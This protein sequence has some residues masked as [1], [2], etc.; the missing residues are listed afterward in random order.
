MRRR[1]FLHLISRLPAASLACAL[2]P[3]FAVAQPSA[4]RRLIDVHAHV[5]NATDLP[6]RRFLKIVFLHLHPQQGVE[7]L[8]ALKDRDVVD[9]LIEL[10]IRI[11]SGR[12]P[13]ARTEIALLDGTGLAPSGALDVDAAG[14]VT[15][16]RLAEFLREPAPTSSLSR[17][18]RSPTGAAK[19][20]RAVQR[21]GS[22][23]ARDLSAA[24][25]ADAQAVAR[26]AYHSAF[27]I[28]TYLRWFT[29]FS[30]YR[31]TLVDHLA[32]I[33][34]QQGYEPILLAPALID[35]SNWLGEEVASPLADQVEVM[36]RIASRAT[37]PAVHG[38]VGFDPLGEVFHRRMGVQTPSSLEV[39][40]MA[41]AE[42]G[43]L[44]VKLY[45]P[46]GFKPAGN[47]PGQQ[48]P[49]EII[50]ALD[51]RVSAD[52]NR[53]L[54][55]LFALCASQSAPLIAHTAESNPAG[56]GYARRADPA[57]W[58]PVLQKY[59]NLRVAFAH[60]GRFAYVSA[61]A[62]PKAK[63]PESSW[64]WT[65][66]SIIAADPARPVYADLS[67]LSEVLQDDA[68]RRQQLSRMLRRF[69]RTYDP[70]V[71]H[72]MFGTDWIMLG[73]EKGNN[74]Y[75]EAV[76]RF[77]QDDCGFGADAMN[78]FFFGNAVRF[79]GL[80]RGEATRGRLTAFYR[81]NNL[82]DRLDAFD[83]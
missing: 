24:T 16:A 35:Y 20:K 42:H 13:N 75:T 79:L 70:D 48:Y 51:G 23:G 68:E 54:D 28:G 1:D 60:F 53:A 58:R 49:R 77:L 32:D 26:N 44:G 76:A 39:V 46:M 45:P 78:R 52:L 34:R 30:M 29:L 4:A 41:I 27:D 67:Y 80:G 50:R 18:P 74:R 82:A 38:Y 8:L 14:E 59:P 6:A 15:I 31:H 2:P 37:G 57:Y 69:V 25:S 73:A 40:R 22:A 7:R 43:F 61:G 62:P 21:A 5:F 64:E 47:A 72:L 71:H 11:T 33:H 66:G 83:A 17:E 9:W 3:G 12:A 81:R 63:L 36:G 10:F 56:P 19:L 55:D 65:F